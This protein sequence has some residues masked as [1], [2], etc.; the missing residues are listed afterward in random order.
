MVDPIIVV[1][2]LAKEFPGGIKAVR[3]VSFDVAPKEIFGFLGPNGAGKSTTL[4]MLTTQLRP[5]GGRATIEGLDVLEHPREIRQRIG[6]VFQEST[7][8][9]EL[10]G[11]ENLE[12]SAALYAV[13][14]GETQGRID[15]LL[16]S[17]KLEDSAGRLVKTYSGGMRRR[18]EIAAGILHTP[19]VLFLDEPTIGLDPQGRAGIGTYIR[20]LRD[21]FGVTVFVTTHY[22]EEADQ[23][24]DRIA[25]I[26][27]GEIRAIGT[28]SELK[29]RLG[30]DVVTLTLREEGADLTSA[31]RAV[32]GVLD[33]QRQD[34]RYR[35]KTARG[36]AIVADAVKCCLDAGAPLA[37]VAVKRPSLDEVFLE[38]TGRE[39]REEEGP[40]AADVAMRMNQWRGRRP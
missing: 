23:L 3:G 32:P 11:R 5:T 26:D 9:D 15:R 7:A 30:G 31:F 36:E 28:P 13:P 22:L 25:I 10:T 29:E 20:E 34:G 6:L 19:H 33:V 17:L 21:K 16:S 38:F 24:C 27:H 12:L 37:T 1:D 14:R 4:G 8:D 35:L 40:S 18:L 2:R 39:Y